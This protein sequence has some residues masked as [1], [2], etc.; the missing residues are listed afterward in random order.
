MVHADSGDILMAHQCQLV[1]PILALERY[2]SKWSIN[3][4]HIYMATM[5]LSF[6]GD[7][8]LYSLVRMVLI[9]CFGFKYE[10]RSIV[11]A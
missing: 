10:Q 3:S 11:V 4:L 7:I 2:P 9:S 6:F 8:Y 1:H 5:I